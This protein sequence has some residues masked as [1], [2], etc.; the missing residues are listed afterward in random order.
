MDTSARPNCNSML[1]VAAML[2][3]TPRIRFHAILNHS[4]P[5]CELPGFRFTRL[6]LPAEAQCLHKALSRRS[7]GHGPAFLYK[8]LLHYVMPRTV[9]RLI[10]L[11]NDCVPLR[12]IRELFDEFRR[13]AG[14]LIGVANEQSMLYQR[15]VGLQGKN[16]GVQLLDLNGMRQ[17]AVYRTAL[18][19]AAH[20]RDGRGKAWAKGAWLGDQTLYTILGADLPSLVYTLPCEWNR[21][22]GSDFL[23]M[24]R[25]ADGF[26]DRD[27]IL[28]APA[29]QRHFSDVRPDGHMMGFTNATVHT[30][31]GRCGLLHANLFELKCIA[32]MMHANP[33]CATWHALQL[34]LINGSSHSVHDLLIGNCPKLFGNRYES[35][36]Q[37]RRYLGHV[38]QRF[39][40]D[41]CL[42]AYRGP[43]RPPETPAG[44]RLVTAGVLR[45]RRREQRLRL[46]GSGSSKALRKNV[47]ARP[48]S[49]RAKRP[50]N[51]H[52]G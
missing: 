22:L 25:H 5:P 41:C 29:S 15:S 32:R 7:W 47:K 31:L 26:K 33:S 42:E 14:R 12:D 43:L 38:L 18:D 3:T 48:R 40:P 44:S 10:L 39:F 24:N 28:R 19:E 6:T 2:N 51:E 1:R 34:A 52:R 4:L 50:R 49:Q 11:D 45:V 21:Q 37:R 17:S 35:V 30:C 20:G 27:R 13:F 36:D 46:R 23:V 16:G 8:P 9:R